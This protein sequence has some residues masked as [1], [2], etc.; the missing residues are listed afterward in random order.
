MQR[1]AAMSMSA[2]ARGWFTAAVVVWMA[3][4]GRPG[5][6]AGRSAGQ[7][8]RQSLSRHPR[9]GAAH[10]GEKA[11]GRLQRRRHRP[12]RQVRV[13][14]RPL[15]TRDRAGLSRHQG[16][17]GPPFRRIREGDQELWRRHV[18]VAAW[19]PCRSRRKRVGDRRARGEPR[20][21]PEVSRAKTR[22]E[23]LSSSSVPRARC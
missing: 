13:G 1:S 15:L 22:R 20:R 14:D 8:R 3:M 11:V 23:A 7:Q 4:D 16:K 6:D 5:P 21:A 18:R 12:G 19:H 2:F 10:S 9:L 17:P